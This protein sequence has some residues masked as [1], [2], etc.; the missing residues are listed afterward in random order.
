MT[1]Q[2]PLI[3]A[4]A[5]TL[6][7]ALL[8]LALNQGSHT[9]RVIFTN[10]ANVVPGQDVRVANRTVGTVKDIS[11]SDGVAVLELSIDDSRIWPLRRGTTAS[12]RTPTT[13]AFYGRYVDL[14]PGPDSG[15]VI[16]AGGLIPRS[17]TQVPVD[18]DEWLNIFDGPTRD[19]L[20]RF[21]HTSAAA[22]EGQ[23][24]E[25]SRGLE[26]APGGIGQVEALFNELGADP[27]AFRTLITTGSQTTH[28]LAESEDDLRTLLS[29][30]AGTMDAVAGR[31]EELQATLSRLPAT[32]QT[33]THTLGRL[34]SSLGTLNGLVN[35]LK[36]GA[37]RLASLARPAERTIS[38]LRNVA[39]PA[40]AALGRGEA[41][42]PV[43]SRF[44]RSGSDLAGPLNQTLSDA[45]P[46]F[47]CIRPYGPEMAG[48]AS[49]WSGF[50]K[51]HDS[52]HHYWRT[53]FMH[54]PVPNGSPLRASELLKIIPGLTYA[55]PRAPGLNAKQP[56]FQ[57]KCGVGPE[58]LDASK[59]PEARK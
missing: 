53:Y 18:F 30:G 44:A 50:A 37:A 57:P 11:Y 6:V 46:A 45:V 34:D 55:F 25:I 10:A 59:D 31:S 56:W 1:L 33:S 4:G 17:S 27:V 2:R 16:A 20:G 24:G 13:I 36:P 42:A 3:V 9:V 26:A 49:T 21:I 38:G 5:L 23:R 15:P 28:A 32:L 29:A 12:I 8:V 43:I 41:A 52:S 7:A 48:W 39:P 47:K 58:S 14:T 51:N 54:P 22:L 19:S 40:T 35:E